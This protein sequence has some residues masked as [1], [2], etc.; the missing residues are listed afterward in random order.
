LRD[1]M[2]IANMRIGGARTIDGMADIG[3]RNAGF[4]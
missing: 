4:A 2:T 3:A 1:S